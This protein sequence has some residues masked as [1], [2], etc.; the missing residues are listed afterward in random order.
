[1]KTRA[2]AGVS[3]NDFLPPQ[4]GVGISVKF[5]NHGTSKNGPLSRTVEFP[6]GVFPPTSPLE[7]NSGTADGGRGIL[8]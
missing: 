2:H 6:H 3:V 4:A 7:E 8:R 5:W 1:M